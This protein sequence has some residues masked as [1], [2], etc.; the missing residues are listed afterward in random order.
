MPEAGQVP[1]SS[2]TAAWLPLGGRGAAEES[3][4]SQRLRVKLR[5]RVPPAVATGRATVLMAVKPAWRGRLRPQPDHFRL[6]HR[7][8]C[9]QLDWSPAA[10]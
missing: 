9:V 5:D 2:G 10:Q 4:G 6:R 7:A 8:S 1:V 3:S